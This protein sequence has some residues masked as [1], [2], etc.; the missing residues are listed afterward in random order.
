M[1]SSNKKTVFSISCLMILCLISGNS[2]AE[3]ILYG[4]IIVDKVGTVYD[5]DTFSVS[6]NQWPAIIGKNISVRLK[7]VD[8]PEMKGACYQ[9]ILKAREAKKFTVQRLRNAKKV[10]LKNMSRDK[11]FRIDADVFIDGKDLAQELIN[12]RLGVA[13]SGGI[14]MNWCAPSIKKG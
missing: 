2:M 3:E 5:G 9:E 10:E 13:Y 7:G 1:N 14:K 11:Y 8:T 12:S 4:N 6:I